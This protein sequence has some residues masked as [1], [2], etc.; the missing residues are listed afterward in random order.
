MICLLLQFGA[1][2]K[3][4]ICGAKNLSNLVFAHSTFFH[5][6]DCFSCHFDFLRILSSD[7]IVFRAL[8]AVFSFEEKFLFKAKVVVGWTCC[9]I[10]DNVC[11][12]FIFFDR[13]LIHFFSYLLSFIISL[14]FVRQTELRFSPFRTSSSTSLLAYSGH[15]P[16]S[17][18]CLKTKNNTKRYFD[19]S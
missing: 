15:T 6:I 16:A 3:R 19:R 11:D 2:V 9:K 12:R 18:R 17:L 13:T 5:P 10:I 1:K 7:K 14:E 4:L 8:R